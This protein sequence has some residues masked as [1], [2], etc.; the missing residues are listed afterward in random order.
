MTI[1]LFI[2][3][4]NVSAATPSIPLYHA[5]YSVS[6]NTLHIGDAQFSLIQEKNGTFT[7]KSVTQAA[8]LAALFF[9]DIITETSH[10]TID[11]GRLQPLVYSYSHSG[12]DHDRLQTIRFDWSKHT[13]HDSEGSSHHVVP[14]TEGTYDRALAQLALS[15]DM[16]AGHLQDDY[17]V[18]DHGK[19]QSYRLKQVGVVKLKTPAG[20]Y[21]TVEVA[22]HEEKHNRTTTFW[23]APKLDYLPVQMQQTEPGKAT[24]SLVLT[25]IKFDT[26][27]SR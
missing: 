11:D 20:E 14:I 19:F 6:R 13:A 8:G 27:N 15:V 1:F 4:G 25:E 17:R 5:T 2:T 23:L 21:D 10:F 7:Y 22:R 9:N 24:I 12:N 16:G 3:A 18:L 26:A